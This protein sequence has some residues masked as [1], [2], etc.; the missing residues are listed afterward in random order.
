MRTLGLALA[1]VVGLV[2]MGLAEEGKKEE[3][4]KDAPKAALPEGVVGFAGVVKG[5]VAV[6]ADRGIGL[7][8]TEVVKVAE[9]SKATDPKAL[10]GLTIKVI[11]SWVKGEEGGKGHPDE[12]QAAFLRQLEA[13][14][15]V[16]LAVKNVERQIFA[17]TELTKEQIEL[18]KSAK[19]P[20]GDKG[21]KK[22]E[23]DR[24]PEG[25]KKPEGE[26]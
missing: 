23:G 8:V 13:N 10:V 26:M 21:E 15:E 11:P 3:P 24:K 6:K 2:W 25:G 20:E 12:L 17:I 1:M 18:A 7:K 22:P 9:A 19:K 4:K 5:T 16:V 14:Q